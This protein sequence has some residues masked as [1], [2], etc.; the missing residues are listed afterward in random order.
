[1]KAAIASAVLGVLL[2]SY[3]PTVLGGDAYIVMFKAIGA[4]TGCRSVV[5]AS[6]A[7]FYNQN[8]VPVTVRLVDGSVGVVP[9]GEP[10]LLLPPGVPTSMALQRPSWAPSGSEQSTYVFWVTHLDVPSGVIIDS[11]DT[12][13]EEL[14]C[15]PEQFDRLKKVAMPVFRSLVP[16]GTPQVKLGTDGGGF[17]AR[18]NVAIFNAGD[19]SAT[20]TIEIRDACNT[21]VLDARTV[22]V[23]AKTIAQFGGLTTG[24]SSCGT[25]GAPDYMRYT[26]VTVDQPS[27]S[28]VTTIASEQLCSFGVLTPV[29][30]LGVNTT[31]DF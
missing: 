5:W 10:T 16:A 9:I 25:G 30:E 14:S 3:S 22:T 2:T 6:D 11:R 21:Q 19:R 17:I 31:T 24:F 27:F 18:E 29:V 23:P 1:M 8:A 4:S 13:R 28:V 15:I 26:V 12:F 20:A 7:V